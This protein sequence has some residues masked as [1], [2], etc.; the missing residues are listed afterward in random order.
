M[1]PDDKAVLVELLKEKREVTVGM[2]GDGA[3]D[4]KALQAAH[5]GVS[6]SEEEASIAAPFTSKVQNISAVIN[7]IREGRCSLSATVSMFKYIELYSFIQYSSIILLYYVG[8][9]I[10]DG[11]YIEID[12]VLTLPLFWLITTTPAT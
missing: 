4:C 2:C 12:L 10:S 11:Q 3:N 6:L 9:D 1:S 5:V 7:L 8:E